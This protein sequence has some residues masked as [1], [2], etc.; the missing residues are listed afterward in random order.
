MTFHE[1]SG[2]ILYKLS[3]PL[4]PMWLRPNSVRV[5]ALVCNDANEILLVRSWFG[6]QLW[7]APGGGVGWG[8]DPKVATLREIREETGVIT[9]ISD[10][11]ELGEL[12]SLKGEMSSTLLGYEAK[13]KGVPKVTGW[14]HRLEILEAAWF[15]LDN[16]PKERSAV[17]DELMLRA[18]H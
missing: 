13:A 5:R 18:G 14:I 6:K 8:E 2:A 15:S 10:L 9:T 16:L 3:K 12:E 4:I 7:S 1:R 11:R 17:V